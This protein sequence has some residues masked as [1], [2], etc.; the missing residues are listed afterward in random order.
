MGKRACSNSPTTSQ[1]QNRPQPCERAAGWKGA[2]VF[3]EMR[4]R[5]TG[6]GCSGGGGDNGKGSSR[7]TY[8]VCAFACV[9]M[10]AKIA[11]NAPS[12]SARRVSQKHNA[13]LLT[14]QGNVEFSKK[15]NESLFPRKSGQKGDFFNMFVSDEAFFQCQQINF[16]DD[17]L[18]NLF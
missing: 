14:N 18:L 2:F 7:H 6:R 15:M 17:C 9:Q 13:V 4:A 12:L 3:G 11:R 10:R 5:Q 16:F 8:I 1:M